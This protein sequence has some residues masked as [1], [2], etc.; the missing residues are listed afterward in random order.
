MKTRSLL[1]VGA[2]AYAS[3]VR[4]IAESLSVFEKIAYVDDTKK[5]TA[6]NIRVISKVY[7]INELSNDFTDVIVA[8]GNPDI[9]NRIINYLKD[10]TTFSVCSLIS[11]L[12]YVSP[13][14][15]ISYGCIVEPFAVISSNSTIGIG[16]I[17]S[18]GAV[19]GHDSVCSDFVHLDYNSVVKSYAKVGEKVK[20]HCGETFKQLSL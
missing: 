6:D 17:I 4:D 9:R 7:D 20:V 19:V 15:K 10:N 5:H 13:T 8:I 12:A 1:I 16:C 11:P 18:S 2:G 3:V 14:A